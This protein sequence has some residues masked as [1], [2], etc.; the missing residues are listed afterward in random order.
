MLIIWYQ[1]Y[2]IKFVVRIGAKLGDWMGLSCGY[3]GSLVLIMMRVKL[4]LGQEL[5][6]NQGGSYGIGISSS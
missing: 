2:H 1:I 4:W 6:G 3:D 5:S